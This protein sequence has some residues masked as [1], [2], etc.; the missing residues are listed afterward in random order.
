M[1]QSNWINTYDI[2]VGD[3]IRFEENVFSGSWRSP[4]FAGKRVV[5]A[6]VTKDSYGQAKQQH[7]FTLKILESSGTDALEVGKVTRRKGRN[8]YRHDP[9]RLLWDDEDARQKVADEKHKRGDAARS[10]RERRREEERMY[11]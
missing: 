9:V 6:T 11:V 1:R 10:D 4:K 3:T 8:I 5:A 7:T 2:V